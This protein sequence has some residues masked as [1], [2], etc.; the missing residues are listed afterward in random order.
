MGKT[1]VRLSENHQ[2][3]ERIDILRS[4]GRQCGKD[5]GRISRESADQGENRY[6]MVQGVS[7]ERRHG[8]NQCRIARPGRIPIFDDSGG[9]GAGKTQVERI[10]NR[11]DRVRIGIRRFREC[12]SGKDTG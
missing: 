7:E 8:S 9:V 5:M 1:R 11:Q 6:S 4:R 10:E 3:R 2:T 12:Q